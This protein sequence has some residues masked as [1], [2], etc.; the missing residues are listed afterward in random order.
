MVVVIPAMGVPARY[1]V[2]FATALVGH[3][4]G[5][6]VSEIRGVGL[7]EVRAS[8]RVN[9]G[10]HELAALDVP[11]VVASL[12]Q[13]HPT[14]PYYLLGHSLGGHI[15]A[16]S[17]AL[18]Q[19][20]PAGLIFVASGTPSLHNW[21]WPQRWGIS[22]AVRVMRV[23]SMLLGYMP[24]QTLGFGGREA[25]QLIAE[26]T[27]FARTGQL[28]PATVPPDWRTQ[29]AQAQLPV[30]AVNFAEDQFVYPGAVTELLQW[31]PNAQATRRDFAA[32]EV[33]DEPVD[34]FRWARR[35]AVP[36][37]EIA[38]WIAKHQP[39]S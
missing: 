13:H 9:F 34:H 16:L 10:Y 5:V 36:A 39:N 30:L 37:A 1:Y 11:A 8:R 35:P 31:F 2:N 32:G 12:Q 3:G 28:T 14:V 27:R 19:V 18:G 21:P 20:A 38:G 29:L 4:L 24:G 33:A 22:A 7:S 6:V 23:T 17:L 15:A 26:W 25:R